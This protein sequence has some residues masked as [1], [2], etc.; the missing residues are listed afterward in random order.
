MG[1]SPWRQCF[2][3]DDV[4]GGHSTTYLHM[5]ALRTS[6][7]GTG[8]G[9]GMD[10]W[11]DEASNGEQAWIGGVLVP[12]GPPETQFLSPC[13]PHFWFHTDDIRMKGRDPREC[14]ARE[15]PAARGGLGGHG[16]E[17]YLLVVGTVLFGNG[18]R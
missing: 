15:A 1:F 17:E 7:V 4:F 2:V 9:M 18:K 16:Y 5:H 8:I 10:G 13:I 11:I 12:F 14:H 3:C 6:A